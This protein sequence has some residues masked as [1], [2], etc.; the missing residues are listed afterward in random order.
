MDSPEAA[1]GNEYQIRSGNDGIDLLKDLKKDFEDSYAE[2]KTMYLSNS[3][4]MGIL[5]KL[6]LI[7]D[8]LEK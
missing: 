6:E 8:E 4:M 2:R 1:Q 7:I 3:G 5:R